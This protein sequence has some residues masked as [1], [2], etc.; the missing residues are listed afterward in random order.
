MKFEVQSSEL[1]KALSLCASILE[2]SNTNPIL[3]NLKISNTKKD[4]KIT[5]TNLT[6]T[7]NAIISCKSETTGEAL[8]D[9]KLF[10]EIA[11]GLPVEACFINLSETKLEIKCGSSNFKLNIVNPEE[12]PKLEDLN[13]IEAKTVDLISLK[14]SLI[15]VLHSA[16]LDETRYTINGVYFHK[17]ENQVLDA[18]LDQNTNIESEK[19]QSYRLVATDGHRISV[20]EIRLS[21]KSFPESIFIPLKSVQEIIRVLSIGAETCIIESNKNSLK[22]KVENF[23]LLVA[24]RGDNFPNYQPALNLSVTSTIKVQREYLI[25]TIKRVTLLQSEK[26][27]PITIESGKDSIRVQTTSKEYGEADELLATINT[28]AETK[29]NFSGKFLLD[30]LNAFENSTEI[31]IQLGGDVSPLRIIGNEDPNLTCIVMPFR[32]N[33]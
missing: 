18:K 23:T 33:N 29:I 12:Y 3:S 25:E 27:K 15:Q 14:K 32:Q 4:L 31:E 30:A 20:S 22:L 19:N 26:L 6:V 21:E 9:G 8:V 11:K 16:S 28:G 17:L 10:S 13:L 1:A 24:L 2:K 5:C 7:I